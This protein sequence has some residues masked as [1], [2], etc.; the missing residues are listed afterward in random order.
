MGLLGVTF[1]II[2]LFTVGKVAT[3]AFISGGL[4]CSI[5]WPSI[6]SL[7]ITGLGK[8]TS[9]GSAFLIMMILGGSIIPPLQGKIADGS[10]NIIPGMSGLH[11]SYIVPVFG[12][13]YIAFFAWKV[14]RELRSQGIDLDH[15]EAAAGH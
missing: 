13:A 2:G 11:F 7:A 4:C 1:M 15:V 8:Y 14:S 5:M 12:F 10:S 6:F 3:F 9:Q